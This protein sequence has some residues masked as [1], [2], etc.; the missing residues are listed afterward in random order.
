MDIRP[1]RKDG[2]RQPV[3]LS[4]AA[5]DREGTRRLVEQMWRTGMVKRVL[6]NDAAIPRTYPAPGHSDHL[7]VEILN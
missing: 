2:L 6:F 4:S 5:Y 3:S 7:H 1:L